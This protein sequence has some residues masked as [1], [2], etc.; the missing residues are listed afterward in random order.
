MSDDPIKCIVYTD[1]AA[2]GDI[3]LYQRKCPICSKI[4]DFDGTMKKLYNV[5]NK[6]VFTHS[7]LNGYTS[8][9]NKAAMAMNS[10][11]TWM[12]RKLMFYILFV[13]FCFFV[14]LFFCFGVFFLE[15]INR[16]CI[17]C[18]H[19]WQNAK[20]SV[21]CVLS[22]F[23]QR[24]QENNP[25]GIK[26]PSQ[27]YFR[28]IWTGFRNKQKWDRFICPWCKREGYEYEVDK[29]V[30]DGVCIGVQKRRC[31]YLIN[32]KE[33]LDKE[34]VD[35]KMGSLPATRFA[36]NKGDQEQL[37]RY[38]VTCCGSFQRDNDIPKMNNEEMLHFS[39]YMKREERY[40]QF[41]NFMDWVSDTEYDTKLSTS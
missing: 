37:L 15:I 5:N 34:T 20:V 33:T 36:L 38:V 13:F 24:Y 40:K 19:R 10:Y 3:D 1:T 22:A 25:K 28:G 16:F 35:V 30:C 12:D 8:A 6:S 9:I 17:L 39:K 32:P 29:L 18:Q 2:Y 41:A 4:Y 27:K 26:F 11:I 14:F 23:L 7:L 21:F 31:I